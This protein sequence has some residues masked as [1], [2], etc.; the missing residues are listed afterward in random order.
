MANAPKARPAT[1]SALY[2]L[3][4]RNIA[5]RLA[6]DDSL[7]A[8]CPGEPERLRTLIGDLYSAKANA[9]APSTRNKDEWGYQWWCRCCAALPCDPLRPT[10][11]LYAE[12]EAFIG[13]F[14]VMHMAAHMQPRRRS[15]KKPKRASPLSAWAAYKHAR[16]VLAARGCKL[17]DIALVRDTL[18]GLMRNHVAAY[19]DEVLAPERKRPFFRKHP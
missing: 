5:D 10:D 6:E 3:A 18:K 7:G 12:R 13:G 11:V 19:G 14:A 8:V 16:T 17:P 1:A 15:A 4:A 9:R 2:A